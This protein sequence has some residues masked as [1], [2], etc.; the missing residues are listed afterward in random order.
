M[1]SV[2]W[3]FPVFYF[4]QG[5]VFDCLDECE[6][7]TVDEVVHC[8][9]GDRTKLSLPSGSRLRGFPVIGL[10]YNK[11]ERLPDEETLLAKFPDLKVVD[12]ERNP[13]F[14]CTTVD[15]YEHIKIV[16]DCFKN[17]TEIS[18][19]PKLFRPTR[20]CDVACQA[21]KHYAKLHEYVLSLWEILK[22]KYENFD[23]DTTLRDIQDFFT[24]VV[25]KINNV[26]QDIN[27]R[28]ESAKAQRNHPKQVTPMP[29]PA[30]VKLVSE[31]ET[32]I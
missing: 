12:V 13:D 32:E 10:T 19:V 2:L 21:S 17:I 4:A 22:D 3:L 9:N 8:H 11:I 7:D 29:E 27:N 1:R 25:K 24:L 31:E 18:K 6:C 5:Y 26:G 20:E 23:L 28:L 30:E 16:S 14:D 15:S